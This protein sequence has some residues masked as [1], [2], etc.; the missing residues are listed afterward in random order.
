[1]FSHEKLHVYQRST[2][3]FALSIE[4]VKALPKGNADLGN[5]LRRAALSI[6]LNIAEGAGKTG[7]SDK[8]RFYGIARGSTLECAAILDAIKILGFSEKSELESG[9]DLLRE[10]AAMLSSLVL[11]WEVHAQGGG[12]AQVHAQAKG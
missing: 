12:E 9:K 10:I 7:K 3:W 8:R 11:K 2:Q 1:M 4:I 6:P 5:Q